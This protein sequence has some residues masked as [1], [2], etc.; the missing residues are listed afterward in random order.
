MGSN[1]LNLAFGSATSGSNL[2]TATDSTSNTGTG[3]V[4]TIGTAGGSS[5]NPFQ[6]VCKGAGCLTVTANGSIGLSN[7]NPSAI[8][9][10]GSPA[11]ASRD[12]LYIHSVS[13]FYPLKVYNGA[14]NEFQVDNAGN[15]TAEGV[16]D[17]FSGIRVS[18]FG[19][20]MGILSGNRFVFNNGNVGIYSSSDTL[21]GTFGDSALQWGS[22]NQFS[23]SNAGTTK[24]AGLQT[25]IR[26]VT[27]PLDTSTRDDYTLLC[28]AV[29]S[30]STEKLPTSPTTG[31][32]RV[33]KK[34]DASP[35]T[36]TLDGNGKN[37]DGGTTIALSAQYK[38][39]KVQYDGTQWWIVGGN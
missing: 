3:Y 28:N 36:C 2:L 29:S 7:T 1:S 24:T 16:F 21:L 23:V 12:G 18:A 25:A 39:T 35:N 15:V 38:Y 26:S 9:E 33:Y 11:F 19:A 14:I 27:A 22:A 8:L 4:A 17:T 34:T 37:I 20:Y 30:S 32:E 10:I 31:E 6:V 5:A 13:G